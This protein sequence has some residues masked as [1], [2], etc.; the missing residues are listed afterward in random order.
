MCRAA[1]M[2]LSMSNRKTLSRVRSRFGYALPGV[3]PLESYT[4]N[5]GQDF[6]AA[7]GGA[8]A[9]VISG[10]PVLNARAPSSNVIPTDPPPAVP[11][12]E[13]FPIS[14]SPGLS[15]NRPEPQPASSPN[16]RAERHGNGAVALARL[17]P[18]PTRPLPARLDHLDDPIDGT[19]FSMSPNLAAAV[20]LV[21]LDERAAIA[22]LKLLRS[23]VPEDGEPRRP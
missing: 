5:T 19:L 9:F 15:L 17:D 8:R 1:E 2:V 18:V 16:G 11:E 13:P 20:S 3:V 12:E 14:Y 7:M 4:I 23:P 10:P 22:L 21:S 6:F